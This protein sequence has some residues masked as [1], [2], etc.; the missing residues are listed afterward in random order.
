VKPGDAEAFAE[1]IADRVGGDEGNVIYFRLAEATDCC[2]PKD[3]LPDLSWDRIKEGF[4]AL[5]NLYG[6][7]NY[8]R[9]VMAYLPIRNKD[10]EFANQMFARIGD[11]WNESVWGSKANFNT[12]T[13]N[14]PDISK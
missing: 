4:G 1:S 12:R 13:V 8:Q 11:D 9:N 3:R 2:G 6:S 14:P 5:E 10:Q 7:L